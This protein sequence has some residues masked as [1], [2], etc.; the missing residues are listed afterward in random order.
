MMEFINCSVLGAPWCLRIVPHLPEVARNR[1]GG[2][3]H[4]H[5]PQE[6]VKLHRQ[7]NSSIGLVLQE[8]ES[9][10]FFYL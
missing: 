3:Y 1:G 2:V 8:T 9:R 7:G 5:S 6:E 10:E 4:T